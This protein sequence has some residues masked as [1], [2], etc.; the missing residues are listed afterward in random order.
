MLANVLLKL[1]L[2]F[3]LIVS[4]AFGYQV[5]NFTDL[6][7]P[8]DEHSVH[9]DI[10]LSVYGDKAAINYAGVQIIAEVART[11]DERTE[12]LMNRDSLPYNGG[13]L[14]I[15][16]SEDRYS[17]WMKNTK[18]PLDII[19]ISAD[20]KVVHI[21]RNAQPCTTPICERFTPTRPA[22]YVLETNPGVFPSS[23]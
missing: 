7:G 17:F 15:F 14:F 3:V 10:V 21:E 11:K 16:D 22:K 1:P 5:K 8:A 13:M 4:V 20:D 2:L 18:I 19:W 9:E 12:G 23:F 6:I